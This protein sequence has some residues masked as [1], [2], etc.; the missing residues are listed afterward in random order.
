M[1]VNWGICFIIPNVY[2]LLMRDRDSITPSMILVTGCISIWGLRLSYYIC[3][4]HKEED[5]RYKELRE[6]WEAK[7]TCYYFYAAFLYV[8]IM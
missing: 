4:R 2:I 1:D 3:K 6:H 5:Y 8:Y 7:G